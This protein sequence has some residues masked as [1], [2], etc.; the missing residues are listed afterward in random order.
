MI[1]PCRKIEEPAYVFK[2]T[3]RK[4]E[5]QARNT[6]RR[7][8]RRQAARVKVRHISFTGQLRNYSVTGISIETDRG[9]RIGHRYKLEILSDLET[10]MVEA[11]V[12]WCHLQAVRP[13]A[14][15]GDFEPFFLAGLELASSRSG[16]TTDVRSPLSPGT[17]MKTQVHGRTPTAS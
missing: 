12:R 7:S 15:A 1:A 2:G 13:G 5:Q 17:A 16:R 9:L 10:I 14:I 4:A 8:P 11:F 3:V 6:R